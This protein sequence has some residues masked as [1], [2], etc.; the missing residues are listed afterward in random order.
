MGPD[1]APLIGAGNATLGDWGIGTITGQD[2]SQVGGA[3]KNVFGAV[4]PLIG[5]AATNSAADA[6]LA[7]GEAE[8]RASEYNA[9]VSRQQAG[10]ALQQ[11]TAQAALVDQENR[12][13]MGQVA[14][15]YGASG[16]EMTGT[17]LEVMSDQATS[18]ELNRQLTLYQGKVTAN[19]LNQ[20]ATLD[21]YRA[22]VSRYSAGVKARSTVLTGACARCRKSTC[23]LRRGARRAPP[24]PIRPAFPTP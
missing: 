2:L 19:N 13:K 23:R 17:P 24:P 11:S 10:T 15:A 4:S 16:V 6:Q 9:Q 20:Q 8:A 18:G 3:V 21:D 5:M 22:Q 7:A 1:S 14:A 12:R